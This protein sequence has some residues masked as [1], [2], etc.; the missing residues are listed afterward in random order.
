MLVGHRCHFASLATSVIVTL[1]VFPGFAQNRSTSGAPLKSVVGTVEGVSGNQVYV[2]SGLQTFALLS[3]ERT[4]VW[5][6]KVFHGLAPVEVG[7]DIIARCQTE[8]SGKLVAEA[9][10]L[11]IVNFFG[12]I[13]KTTDG[14]FELFTNPNADPQSAYKQENKIIH[15]DDGTMF[16]SSAREDLKAG[17]GV[18]VVG[19]HLKNGSIQATRVTVYEGNRPVRIGNG[20]IRLPNG[21]IR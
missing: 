1:A 3:D 4:Q 20:K 17:R 13:T 8:A 21:Q 10:W 6:G 16:D 11:N 19:L 12:V 2:K 9:M 18:Q 7:D 14:E 5:K 15:V